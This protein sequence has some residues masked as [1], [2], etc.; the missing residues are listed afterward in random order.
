MLQTYY[1]VRFSIYLQTLASVQLRTSPRKTDEV[2]HMFSKKLKCIRVIFEIIAQRPA[3]GSQERVCLVPERGRSRSGN[4]WDPRRKRKN[5]AS[6]CSSVQDVSL[7]TPETALYC[8]RSS[9]VKSA[10]S[11][12]GQVRS[13]PVE[14]RQSCCKFATPN[15]SQ[16]KNVPHG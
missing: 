4:Q 16:P 11:S 12:S 14:L 2:F 3:K 7:R 13:G 15:V 8:R 1:L 6:P 5:A 10:L 9:C